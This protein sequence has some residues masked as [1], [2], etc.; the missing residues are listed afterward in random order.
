MVSSNDDCRVAASSTSTLIPNACRTASLTTS[1][2]LLMSRTLTSLFV[3][4]TLTSTL[5]SS[6]EISSAQIGYWPFISVVEYADSTVRL[7]RSSEMGLLSIEK[8]SRDLLP[9][10]TGGLTTKPEIL[11]FPDEWST[12]TNDLATS[13]PQRET[14]LSFAP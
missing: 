14:I 11:I 4:C 7:R 8:Y 3:G 1:H 5:E 10:E 2:T 13:I 12:L 6:I 9:R